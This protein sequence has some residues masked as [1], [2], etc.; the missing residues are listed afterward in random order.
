MMNIAENI[1]KV[2]ARIARACESCGRD[3]SEVALL[4]VSKKKDVDTVREAVNAGQMLLGENRIQEVLVKQPELSSA[5]S[6]HLIGHLQSNKVKHAIHCRF[7]CIHSVDS[8][9]LMHALD[10]EAAE[11]G[12]VQNILLQVNVSGEGSKFGIA[13]EELIPLLE[14]AAGCMHISVEG[15][16]TIPPV[17]EDPEKAGPYFRQLRELRDRAALE[18]GFSLAFLSMGMSHDMEVAIREG[19]TMV[20]VGTDIFGSRK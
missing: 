16:M 13:P 15:L 7:A 12:I 3:P 6:W 17:S 20:R 4:A 1:E 2:Q 18:T 9:K 10:K 11:Q 5:V 19:A 8:A 14:E